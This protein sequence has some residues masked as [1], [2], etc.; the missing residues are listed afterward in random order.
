MK[1]RFVLFKTISAF[2]F[3]IFLSL[4]SGGET[5]AQDKYQDFQNMDRDELAK[6]IGHQMIN[7]LQDAG[8]TLDD[9]SIL[10]AQAGNTVTRCECRCQDPGGYVIGDSEGHSDLD[11]PEGGCDEL[12]GDSCTLTDGR[13]GNYEDCS[14]YERERI[15]WWN[16]FTWFPDRVQAAD[17]L[18]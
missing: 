17:S 13:S 18:R 6:E 12:E 9:I 4:A 5:L 7:N 2:V 16:P 1:T 15:I 11:V 14:S 10:A 3:S 8:Y